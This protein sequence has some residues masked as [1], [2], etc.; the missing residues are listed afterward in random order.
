MPDAVEF[1]PTPNP[2]AGKFVVGRPVTPVGT[3][4]SYYTPAEASDDPIARGIMALEGVRSVFMVNDFVTVTKIPS[5]AWEE[6]A[7]AVSAILDR[8]V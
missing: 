1:Q 8:V 6:L 5:V 3:S 7:P 2:N 4:R